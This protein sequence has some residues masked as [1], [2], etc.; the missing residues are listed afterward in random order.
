MQPEQN[1]N[2][3]QPSSET[4]ADPAASVTT[5]IPTQPPV[6]E[7]EAPAPPE[8]AAL[9][10]QASEFVHHEKDG[11]WFL[12]LI[13]VATVLLLLDIFLIRSWTF[14]ALIVVMTVAIMV[15]AR[16]PPRT[17]NYALSTHGLQIDEKQ[18]NLHDFRAFGV[19]QEN[20]FYSIRLIPN[21]RFMPMVSVFFP[22][23]Q[24]EEIV[25]VFG[26]ALPMEN[27]KR[28]PIDKLVEKIRF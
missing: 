16:R 13:G 19:V 17:I 28:D 8:V 24:G 21:K 7:L 22:P 4:P 9:S 18:F 20:A 3:W 6:E 27:I 23:E 11:M 12:A 25:D 2:Y 15:V 1:Q 5:E 26:Q 10:W 14:G